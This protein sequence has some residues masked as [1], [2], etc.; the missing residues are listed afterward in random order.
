M[1]GDFESVKARF[2]QII[3]NLDCSRVKGNPWFLENIE[4]EVRQKL[5]ARGSSSSDILD[6][7]NR[8]G[9]KESA[10]NKQKRI[11]TSIKSIASI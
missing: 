3:P 4:S 1:P 2:E 5:T 7:I 11:L 10:E 8:S 9:F 6:E